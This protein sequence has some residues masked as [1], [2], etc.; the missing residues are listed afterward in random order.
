MKKI[1]TKSKFRIVVSF[2]VTCTLILL[3]SLAAMHNKGHAVQLV[4]CIVFSLAAGVLI[5]LDLK[6]PKLVTILFLLIIPML[7]L[8]G[9]E[10]FTHEITDI[11]KIVILLN[12]VF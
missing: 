9:I 8:I 12:L 3:S 7:S 11:K 1:F 2:L 5:C 4:F 6:I 10:S